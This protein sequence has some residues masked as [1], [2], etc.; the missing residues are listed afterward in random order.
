MRSA[1]C[2][3]VVFSATALFVPCLCAQSPQ[4]TVDAAA[5][6][7]PIN[8]W[9]YGINAWQG[10]G[11]QN[12][13]RIPLIRWGG[14]DATSFNWQNSVKNNTGDNPWN[15]ENYSVSPGFD[16]LHEADLRA[17]T[18]TLGTVSLMDWTPSA[19]GPCSFRSRPRT[20][21]NGWRIF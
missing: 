16:A 7:H 19:A 18:T 6:R 10:S 1:S 12:M 3:L 21:N 20:R 17:G 5:S 4:L 13:M 9:I 15:Y 14:D 11:L 8:S 2:G